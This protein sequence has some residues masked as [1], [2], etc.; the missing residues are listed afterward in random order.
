MLSTL[1]VLSA[2]V[3]FSQTVP[4]PVTVEVP[5]GLDIWWMGFGLGATV[6][7]FRAGLRW[8]KRAPGNDSES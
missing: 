4:D 7:V 3:A 1:A 5:D 6:R 2:S 8:V